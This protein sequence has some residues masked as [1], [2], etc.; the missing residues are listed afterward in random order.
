MIY[1]AENSQLYFSFHSL[2]FF[3]L[4]VFFLPRDIFQKKE[5][6]VDVTFKFNTHKAT[7]YIK[8]KKKSEG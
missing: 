7:V 1:K 5:K 6:I 3:F 2:P 8:N 4:C